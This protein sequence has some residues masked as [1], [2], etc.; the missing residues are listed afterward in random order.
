MTLMRL[1]KFLSTA[2]FCSRRKGE[3]LIISGNVSVNGIVITELGTKVDTEKDRVHVDGVEVAVKE[4]LIYIALNKPRGVVT[5]CSQ[6]NDKIVMDLIDIPQRVYPVGRLDKDSTG[7][8]LLTN[9]GRLHH[10]LS[11]PSFDHE[12][13]YEVEVKDP[14]SDKALEKMA[15]GMPILGA[16]TRPAE[17]FRKSS[18]KFRM[19]LKEGKNRQIRRMVEHV[20]NEVILL[21]R[22]RISGVTLGRLREGQW[23]YLSGDEQHELLSKA[24]LTNT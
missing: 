18:R 20:G 2:G 5:S 13:E 17:V 15:K 9:D 3:T 7:L 1:Q 8:L 10:R 14:I 23:R 11:H 4:N 24:L 16:K 21:K 12:K 6:E 19:V 22:V